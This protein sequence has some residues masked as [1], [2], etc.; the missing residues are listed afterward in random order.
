MAILKAKKWG[1][2]AKASRNS[3]DLL[4]HQESS[5]LES[6]LKFEQR[7]I[8]D[9]GFTSEFSEGIDAFLEKRKANF[10]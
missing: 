6:H 9:A 8:I 4:D 7:K 5:D 1:S 2:W 10:N 3:K